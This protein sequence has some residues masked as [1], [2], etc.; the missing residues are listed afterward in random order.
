M[1]LGWWEEF[2]G[3]CLLKWGEWLHCGFFKSLV[4]LTP[5]LVA[6]I[7]WT[8]FP[9]VGKRLFSKCW[10]E[11]PKKLIKNFSS[12]VS[13][14]SRPSSPT[15]LHVHELFMPEYLYLIPDLVHQVKSVH[16]S[17]SYPYKGKSSCLKNSPI[18]DNY[19]CFK[20]GNGTWK[21]RTRLLF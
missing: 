16:H 13:S 6:P 2:G 14:C 7:C 1:G 9:W 5:E 18:R 12:S 3:T 10:N 8:S 4:S 21:P 17:T 15:T 19:Q 11:V 20:W